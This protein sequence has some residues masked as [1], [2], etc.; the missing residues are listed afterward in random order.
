MMVWVHQI[1]S[2]HESVIEGNH[3]IALEERF[4]IKNFTLLYEASFI[5]KSTKEYAGTRDDSAA[6]VI[7]T[8]LRTKYFSLV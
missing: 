3:S 2:Q 6:L 8:L 1:V 5:F 4:F 7:A